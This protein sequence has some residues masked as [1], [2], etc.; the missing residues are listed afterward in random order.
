M[1]MRG[2]TGAKWNC[3]VKHWFVF[4]DC[5]IE[6]RARTGQV[7]IDR[8]DPKALSLFLQIV[9]DARPDAIICLGDMAHLSPI[10]PWQAAKGQYGQMATRDGE[11]AEGYLEDSMGAC[12]LFLDLMHEAGRCKDVTI[13]EGNHEEW[14]R[15][16][17][18]KPEY[19]S[20]RD[21]LW[22]PEKNWEL[23]KR[24]YKF[25]TYQKYEDFCPENWVKIGRRKVLHGF[26]VAQNFL[27]RHFKFLQ[28]PFIIG[29]LHTSESKSFAN[30]PEGWVYD[31]H[32][33]G[34]LCTKEASYHRGKLNRWSQGFV[35]VFEFSNGETIVCHIPFV[36]GV[37]I[38][39]GKTYIPKRLPDSLM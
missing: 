11:W 15:F 12:N 23:K 31:G 25:K 22:Y 21:D 14:L 1:T 30:I 17:R 38:Y 27:E 35:E 2:R 10:S 7:P 3:S 29:H 4:G 36:N 16:L 28:C 19:K 24:G 39:R 26:W 37:A 8:H 20:V 34:C 32:S 13:M 6:A 9:K 18:N 33:I 5:H